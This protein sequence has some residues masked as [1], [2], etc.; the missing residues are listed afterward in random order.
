[1]VVALD[2][3]GEANGTIPLPP[4]LSEPAALSVVGNQVYVLGNQQ[5]KVGIFSP[6]GRLRGEVRWDGVQFPTAFA[7]D[8]VR[9]WFLVA[10]PKWVIVQGFDP[11]G[12]NLFAFGQMGEGVDQMQ[13]VDSLYVDPQGLVYVVDSRHGKVLVFGSGQRPALSGKL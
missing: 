10:D 3:E 6:A 12:K 13:R 7:Y 1:V 2:R 4:E 11:N 8:P 9:R 5:H